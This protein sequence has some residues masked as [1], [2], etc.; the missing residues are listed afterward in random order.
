MRNRKNA[1]LLLLLALIVLLPSVANANS[2]NPP[3]AI[4]V[5]K[6]I[7]TIQ[8]LPDHGLTAKQLHGDRDMARQLFSG[9]D[10][11]AWIRLVRYRN[12]FHAAK[13]VADIA[14]SEKSLLEEADIG[15][16][17]EYARLPKREYGNGNHFLVLSSG[18]WTISVRIEY[19]QGT[20]QGHASQVAVQF[21]RALL[22]NLHALGLGNEG[23]SASA[24]T[25]METQGTPGLGGLISGISLT[26]EEEQM[27]IE[28]EV[29][30]RFI[31]S[32]FQSGGGIPAGPTVRIPMKSTGTG[33]RIL[34]RR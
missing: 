28:G 30:E 4:D 23:A 33:F 24:G 32:G 9:K 17:T 12:R 29:P 7:A 27:L 8:K 18:L 34:E 15:N 31:N 14:R 2:G 1:P 20:T 13:S 22:S 16:A 6:E 5:F 25:G 10:W 11:A 26:A 3:S 21:A 19:W